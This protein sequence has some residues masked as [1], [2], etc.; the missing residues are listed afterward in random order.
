MDV[1]GSGMPPRARRAWR[2][3][4]PG[5]GL[6]FGVHN[7][8][9]PNLRRG[10]MERVF[11][12]EKQGTLV[13]TPK[14]VV[15]A[16]GRLSVF[17]DRLKRLHGFI[18]PMDEGTFLS[19]YEGR[20]RAVYEGAIKS[21]G[22]RPLTRRDAYLSTFV[23]AE[24]INF[25]SKAD[26]A[27]RV[28]Q[29]RSPRYN[30]HVG[31][32]LR[33]LESRIYKLISR[34]WGG[35]TVMKHYNYDQVAGHLHDMWESFEDP[36]AI[37]LDASRF[38]QHVS[39]E[40]LRWEHGIYTSFYRGQSKQELAKLLEWQIVNKGFGRVP[41]GNIKYT[42]RGCRMSGDMNTALGNCLL[43]SAMVWTL[44]HELGIKARLS[45]N[46]DDCVVFMSRKDC[47][48]FQRHVTRWFLDMG[49]TMKVEDPVDVFEKV[50]FCQAQP[51]FDG[52]GWT[53]VR[54]P[55]V[56]VDKDCFC[57]MGHLSQ[58]GLLKWMHAVG[59]CGASIAGD[60]PV[61][62]A[63]Y[64]RFTQAGTP[65]RVDRSVWMMDSG[66]VRLAKHCTRSFG[67][68]TAEARY[69][70]WL[71]FGITPEMQLA[72]EDEIAATG[73]FTVG[74]RRVIDQFYPKNWIA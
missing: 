44:C 33:H 14:P 48:L 50:V 56:A 12:V 74:P 46:G 17:A 58:P 65:G 73:P 37:G 34:V 21:L 2:V 63:L 45:N 35:P 55:M 72:L 59:T 7:S 52:R 42:V 1:K 71:A 39:E 10:L 23:K 24:K 67:E 68:P 25:S 27:P 3:N 69:S 49:F 36:V 53:M 64:K 13:P 19:Y 8:D 32:Y 30:V 26:P 62:C 9:L 40:A 11:F 6:H 4:G 38:D 16:F 51:V 60:I 43:M 66:F 70:F 31:K 57:T 18:A 41:D 15:G 28:I 22:V 47:S 5:R 20:K 29:P 54:D 61:F